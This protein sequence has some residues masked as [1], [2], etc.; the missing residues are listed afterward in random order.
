MDNLAK[1]DVEK[2][3]VWYDRVKDIKSEPFLS[4]I[5]KSEQEERAENVIELLSDLAE[6]TKNGELDQRFEKEKIREATR[7]SLLETTP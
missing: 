6:K 7:L 5:S 3:K 1:Q 2:L 4:I